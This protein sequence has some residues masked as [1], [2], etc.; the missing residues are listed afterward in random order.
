MSRECVFENMATEFFS[1]EILQ[2]PKAR[3]KIS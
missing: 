2:E 1:L 3:V